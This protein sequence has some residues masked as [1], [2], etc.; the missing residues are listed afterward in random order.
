MQKN[1]RKYWAIFTLPTLICF[2]IAFFVPFILGFALSFTKFTT[3]TDAKFVGLNN[4]IKAFSGDVTFLP[5]LER[6]LIVA[7]TCIILVN[8]LAFIFALLLT[9]KMHGTN[10]FRTIFFMPNLI[11]GIVLGYIW[12]LIFDGILAKYSLTLTS[13]GKFGVIG[14]IIMTCWQMIGYM[15]VIYIAG[16]QNVSPDLIEAA[17]IDGATYW[18][19]LIHVKIPMVMPSVTICMFMTLTNSFK[20]FN[21]NLSL[22]NGAPGNDSALIALDIFHTFY[23]R[24]GFE[25]IGQAEAV[26][27]AVL[28]AVI[29]WAQL[30]ITKS[31]EVET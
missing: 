20:I 26:V 19:T 21:Q 18:Q 11:G 30:K 6:T 23:N 13:N 12:Q 29:S 15:M 14:L 22:T 16:L 10:V 4:Y 7:I 28:L 1:L 27:F 25:G 5:A 31:R 3:V 2:A 8:L 17:K 9:R 24:P